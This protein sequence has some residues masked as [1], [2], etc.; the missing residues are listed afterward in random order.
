[1][2]ELYDDVKKSITTEPSPD[3]KALYQRFLTMYEAQSTQTTTAVSQLGESIKW[4]SM[5]DL[6][7]AVGVNPPNFSLAERE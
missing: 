1:M 4:K 6:E 5:S 2:K 7:K 3:T